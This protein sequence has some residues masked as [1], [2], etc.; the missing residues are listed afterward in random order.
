VYFG[1]QSNNVVKTQ[2]QMAQMALS[3]VSSFIWE[4]NL[5]T[6][7]LE[8]NRKQS[9]KSQCQPSSEQAAQLAPLPMAST[10]SSMTSIVES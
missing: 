4:L 8:T 7:I 9:Y 10:N 2:R 6:H 1:S 5:P 3:Q